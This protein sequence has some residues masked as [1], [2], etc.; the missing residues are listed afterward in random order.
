MT[1][2]SLT[3]RL[4]IYIIIGF[5]AVRLKIVDKTFHKQLSSL[6]MTFVIPALILRSFYTTELNSDT[7][8]YLG[9][10]FML[11]VATF[12]TLFVIGLIAHKF[13]KVRYQRKV[14]IYAMLTSNFTFFGMPLVE[15][16][17]GIE[18]VFYYTIF[19]TFARM[20]YYGSPAYLLGDGEKGS[21]KEFI[22]HMMSPSIVCV[23]GG[24]I[25]YLIQFSPPEFIDT[26][27]SGLSNTCTPFGM[28]LC[29]MTLA[30]APLKEA[31]SQPIL[32]AM[33]VARLLICPAAVLVVCVMCG[34]STL[35]TEL[36]VLY[37]AMPFGALLPTFATR[38]CT[39][40]RSV[41][42]SSALVSLSTMLC[43][44]TIPMWLYIFAH[45]F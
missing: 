5:A 24:F 18:G 21:I 25:L 35:F 1:T 8:S 42:Y 34:F 36:A 11:T 41:I 30:G 7:M 9:A 37:S 40:E 33:S 15:A 19:T 3:V 27:M 12:S 13:T 44:A 28:M 14:T 6:M 2:L 39:D 38:Y 16:V 22:K 45:I 31:F 32:I 26:A 43:I 4:T 17:Y 10:L 23:F 29:G 20:I